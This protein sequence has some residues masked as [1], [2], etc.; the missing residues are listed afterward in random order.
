MLAFKRLVAPNVG[1]FSFYCNSFSS[2]VP[3]AVNGLVPKEVIKVRED[4]FCFT[5][6][7]PCELRSL[8]RKSQ[9]LRSYCFET[10]TIFTIDLCCLYVYEELR[11]HS[12]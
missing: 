2:L 8:S 7:S 3:A 11:L 12:D 10:K 9:F 5:N 1:K 4:G 6:K